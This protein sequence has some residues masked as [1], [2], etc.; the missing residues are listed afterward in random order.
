LA[1]SSQLQLLVLA[2]D[3]RAAVDGIAQFAF[4]AQRQTFGQG[5]AG[6][7]A[8]Q[9]ARGATSALSGSAG[10][11]PRAPR[12]CEITFSP[13]LLGR[14]IHRD[15]AVLQ[16]EQ[17]VGAGRLDEGARQQLVQ[18]VVLHLLAHAPA[19]LAAFLLLHFGDLARQQVVD[20]RAGQ[21]LVLAADGEPQRIADAVRELLALIARVFA[22][23]NGEMKRLDIS[24]G[25]TGL[26]LASGS[27]VSICEK[28]T[29]A[30]KRKNVRLRK[31]MRVSGNEAEGASLAGVGLVGCAAAPASHACASGSGLSA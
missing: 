6:D 22:A 23:P 7:P 20:H 9:H 18:Q 12:I 14:G 11:L 16:I 27:S 10:K 5:L 2:L 28:S 13:V 1:I 21:D 31:N 30:G 24:S 4:L 8:G 17:R 29:D 19:R 15:E 25:P 26:S 3:H